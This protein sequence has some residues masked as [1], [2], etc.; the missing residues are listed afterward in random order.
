M[1]LTRSFLIISPISVTIQPPYRLNIKV[2]HSLF[3]VRRK[4][5]LK[6]TWTLIIILLLSGCQ[7]REENIEPVDSAHEVNGTIIE[8]YQDK[9]LLELAH[10]LQENEQEIWVAV[11]DEINI[12]NLQEMKLDRDSLQIQAEVKVILGNS[13]VDTAPRI[14]YAKEVFLLKEK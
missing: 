14:C 10:E 11:S 5:N 6:K 4:L 2:K 9:I 8:I 3:N 13:C 12:Q 7:D 1:R